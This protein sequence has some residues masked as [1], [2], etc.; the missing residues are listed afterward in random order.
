MQN[1]L[2]PPILGRMLYARIL[3]HRERALDG[4]LG[5]SVNRVSSTICTSFDA[6]DRTKLGMQG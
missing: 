2:N 3:P 1:M 4:G 5:L 6:V